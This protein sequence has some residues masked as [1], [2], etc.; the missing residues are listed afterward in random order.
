MR[1]QIKALLKLG[2]CTDEEIEIYLLL[3]KLKEATSSELIDQTGLNFMMVYRCIDKLIQKDLL[4]KERSQGRH[5]VLKALPLD[6]LIKKITSE[7]RKT[8][9]LIN[10]LKGLN[11][12]L[13]Y[14]NL[15]EESGDNSIQI[16]EGRD[17]FIEEYLKLASISKS[18][19]F[20][21]GSVNNLWKVTGFDYYSAEERFFI[22][23]R[24]TRG[25]YARLIDESS[26]KVEE[27]KRRDTLEKR[28]TKLGKTIPIKKNYL[29]IIEDQVNLFLCDQENPRVII[30]KEPELI[31]FYKNIFWTYWKKAV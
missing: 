24:M 10:S 28:K 27:M 1:R 18:E 8:N 9:R 21:I 7:Q 3:L 17:A 26:E 11:P 15:E 23:K 4:L 29:A 30:M 2:G 31:D 5:F 19:Y 14:L 12:F 25:I 20:H 16:R 13:Q 6:S 22:R